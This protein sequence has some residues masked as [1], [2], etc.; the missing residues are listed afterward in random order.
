MVRGPYFIIST[1][2]AGTTP[3]FN[4][5]GRTGPSTNRESNPQ[6]LLDGA[7]S[8]LLRSAG[9]T[10]DLFVTRGLH[11]EPPPRIPTGLATADRVISLNR[12]ATSG[13]PIVSPS[14]SGPEMSPLP[15]RL[16]LGVT[17]SWACGS[18]LWPTNE[19]HLLGEF[20]YW[21]RD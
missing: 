12:H 9:V 14:I 21:L 13:P 11:Q 8:P 17:L 16:L 4:V 3:I 5:F 1:M 19:K 15:E 20:N 10:E 7:R 6:Y 2:Q 18:L